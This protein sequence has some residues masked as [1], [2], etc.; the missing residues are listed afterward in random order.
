LE[1]VVL[2]AATGAP[3][4]RAIKKP[5]SLGRAVLPEQTVGRSNISDED[6]IN[7]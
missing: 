6:S 4:E 7:P 3:V 5:V 1:E 2:T